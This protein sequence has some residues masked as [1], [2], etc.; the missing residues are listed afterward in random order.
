MKS[1]PRLLSTSFVMARP[2]LLSTVPKRPSPSVL[3]NSLIDW[4]LSTAYGPMNEMLKMWNDWEHGVSK[5]NTN[6]TLALDIKESDK[7]F[8]L[9]VDVPGIE[10]EDIKITIKD[11]VMT[12]STER[13]SLKKQENENFKRIERFMGMSSRSLTLPINADEENI[14]ASSE[15]G[16][17]N[18]VIPKLAPSPEKKEDSKKI[19]VN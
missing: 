8:Q 9:H 6:P 19:A 1:I 2:K 7:E 12:I 3:S 16:V 10:K 11:H 15:N 13:K 18:I 5:S 14:K 4:P 17:L